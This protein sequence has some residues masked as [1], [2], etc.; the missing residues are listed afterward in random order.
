MKMLYISISAGNYSYS[1]IIIPAT[2]NHNNVYTITNDEAYKSSVCCFT[3]AS[4]GYIISN[5]IV[6][7]C[8]RN[9][10]LYLTFSDKKCALQ[11]RGFLTIVSVQSARFIS[12]N[13]CHHFLSGSD[14]RCVKMSNWSLYYID[15]GTQ[16]HNKMIF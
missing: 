10:I 16:H 2:I 14:S 12:F 3:H 4:I 15:S 7:R 5:K 13:S 11:T 9:I 6:V 8:I 1:Y